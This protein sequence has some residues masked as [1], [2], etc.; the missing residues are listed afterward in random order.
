M[1]G[2]VSLCDFP[3][4]QTRQ[5]HHKMRRSLARR[6]AGAQVR[7][8]ALQQE[9]KVKLERVEETCVGTLDAAASALQNRRR[10]E[11][12][13]NLMGDFECC[14]CC[15][16]NVSE[17]LVPC[18]H[19][20]CCKPHC[21]SGENFVECPICMGRIQKKIPI[22]GMLGEKLHDIR[23]QGLEVVNRRDEVTRGADRAKVIPL[24]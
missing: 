13:E 1:E 19:S 23:R 7:S 10:A 11:R 14:I 2:C 15:D 22:A 16:A 5:E 8:E 24:A 6:I 12:L 9:I 21:G 3:A 17:V 20:F 18:G 4:N